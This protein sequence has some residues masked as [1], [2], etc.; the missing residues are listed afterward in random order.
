MNRL[1]AAVYLDED[2]SVVLADI[3]RARGFRSAT[4][5]D[6]LRLGATDEEQL[7]HA[8]KQQMVLLTHNRVHFETLHKR[9][10]AAGREHWGIIIALRSDAEDL[11]LMREKSVALGGVSPSEPVLPGAISSSPRSASS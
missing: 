7:E 4:T 6:A 2:V 3:L 5:R 11:D 8:S 10:L 1:F 9:Y